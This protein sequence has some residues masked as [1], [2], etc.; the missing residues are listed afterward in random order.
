MMAHQLEQF[1]DGTTAFA[2]REEAWHKLGTI[3][4][5]AFT[6]EEALELAQLDSE[7]I[8]S[9]NPV[10]AVVDGQVL[11]VEDKFITYRNHPKTGM[12]ALGVVGSR[13]VPIQNKDAFSFLNNLVDQSGAIFETAG[14]IKGGR[15][16]FMAVQMPEELKLA[17]GIDT[18]KM[19]IMAT[20]S[21][22]GSQSFTVA[23]TPIRVVCTNTVR[24]GLAQA[25]SKINLRHT[26]SATG[27]VA[28]AKEVLGLV[29]DYQDAFSQEVDRLIDQDF[30][31]TQ[32]EKLVNDLFPISEDFKASGITKMTNKRD[33]L[34][35]LWT[36]PTQKNIAGTKWAAYNAVAEYADWFSPVRGSNRDQARAERIL[37]GATDDLKAKA[38]TLL[39]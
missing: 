15:Q 34:L 30:T 32:F 7:V 37:T 5:R 6:A 18:H 16:V 14:S 26:A 21:H 29:Y 22:D 31:D 19:F 1:E 2:S 20:N 4:K 25:V 10:G 11:T 23:V 36:A 8:V 39:G 33:D 17:N 28:Q 24:L 3:T 9:E 38:L 27:K 13:Y 35:S 12:S